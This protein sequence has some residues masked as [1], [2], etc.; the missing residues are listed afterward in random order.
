MTGFILGYTPKNLEHE[1]DST[2]TSSMAGTKTLTGKQ[3]FDLQKKMQPEARKWEI[4]YSKSVNVEIGVPT[5]FASL[6]KQQIRWRKSFIRSVF[7]FGAVYWKRPFPMNLVYYLGIILRIVRPYI[8]FHSLILLP[9]VGDYITPI[10]FLTSIFFIGMVHGIDYR[11]RNPGDTFW[12]YRPIVTMLTTF[13]LTWLIFIAL[14]R[15]KDNTWR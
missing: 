2:P 5:T 6:I 11:L 9:F 15:I 7:V 12:L 13:V 4:E 8:I 1:T 10:F 3:S 14:I